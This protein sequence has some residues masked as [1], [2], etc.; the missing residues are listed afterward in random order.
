MD[1]TALLQDPGQM[2]D[3]C[4]TL[5]SLELKAV[6]F[7]YR[8][9][10][11]IALAGRQLTTGQQSKKGENCG[12]CSLGPSE[13]VPI[14]EVTGDTAAVVPPCKFSQARYPMIS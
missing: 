11:Q 13:H 5:A 6:A 12:G 1:S 3:S 10:S 9:L 7:N 2:Q 14:A 4:T 8:R